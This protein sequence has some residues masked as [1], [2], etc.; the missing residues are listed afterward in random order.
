MAQRLV[1]EN[2]AWVPTVD[3]LP[4]SGAEHEVLGPLFALPTEWLTGCEKRQDIRHQN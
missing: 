1:M 4:A 2:R 3:R